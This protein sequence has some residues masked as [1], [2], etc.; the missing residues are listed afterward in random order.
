[1]N[2]LNTQIY[3]VM[4][5]DG[6]VI[7]VDEKQKKSL[8]EI[9]ANRSIKTFEIDGNMYSFAQISK[10]LSAPDY[11]EQYPH[12]KPEPKVPNFTSREYYPDM[13]SVD[14]VKIAE[15]SKWHLESLLKGFKRGVIEMAGS[16]EKAKPENQEF[17]RKMER[18]LNAM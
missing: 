15:K 3:A 9:S 17:I 1:M 6:S 11:W 4:F 8:F 12:K 5:F 14:P 18:K 7:W 16:L 13:R 10:I 2:E